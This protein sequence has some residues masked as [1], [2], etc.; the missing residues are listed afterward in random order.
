MI[1]CVCFLVFFRL[2]LVLIGIVQYIQTSLLLVRALR[3]GHIPPLVML[4]CGRSDIFGYST[5][6]ISY[7]RTLLALPI[8]IIKTSDN[9][10]WLSGTRIYFNFAV[11]ELF[12]R[13]IYKFN[14][15]LNL[16]ELNFVILSG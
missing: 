6:P 4:V 13:A 10:R 7:Y 15:G 3:R 11:S 9:W 5:P 2:F 1:Y 12:N 14:S 8:L 16:T